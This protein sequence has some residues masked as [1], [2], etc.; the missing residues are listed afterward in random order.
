MT[1]PYASDARSTV[2]ERP[3]GRLG[4]RGAWVEQS[5]AVCLWSGFTHLRF[6]TPARRSLH[7]LRCGWPSSGPLPPRRSL[8][9]VRAGV[10][11]LRCV[12]PTHRPFNYVPPNS[13][14]SLP[15]P[16]EQ[17]AM[18]VVANRHR[19]AWASSTSTRGWRLEGGAAK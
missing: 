15:S 3:P 17:C 11:N 13:R 6:A 4:K 19:G 18:I 14:A 10:A 1:R 2:V 8:R 16:P 5:G 7:S 9:T 12:K